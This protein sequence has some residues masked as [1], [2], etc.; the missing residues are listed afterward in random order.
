[1]NDKIGSTIVVIVGGFLALATIAVL[2][3][4]NAKTAS[5]LQALGTSGSQVLGAATAPVTGSTSTSV[6]SVTASS[7]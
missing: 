6:P 3:S 1:M 7:S 5:I 4:Q 2:V